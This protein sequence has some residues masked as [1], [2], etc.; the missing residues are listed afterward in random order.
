M[1][2]IELAIGEL[3]TGSIVIQGRCRGADLLARACACARGLWVI[4]V[5]VEDEH[6][7][8]Y[9][10]SA[11]HRRNGIMLELIPDLVL[12]FQARPG[13]GGTQGTLD[14]AKRH[15]IATIEHRLDGSTIRE[16]G[17]VAPARLI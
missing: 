8:R 3:P 14:G 10:G 2:A 12:A 17:K 15:G 6:W 11:G 5:P 7:H 1:R 13:H 4:D 9:G 16:D